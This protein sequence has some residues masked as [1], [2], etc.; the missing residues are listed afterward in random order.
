MMRVRFTVRRLMV[1]VALIAIVFPVAR[2]V[3]TMR[4]RSRDHQFEADLEDIRA[5][6]SRIR[7][8]T[9]FRS[10]SE[11]AKAAIAAD[12]HAKRSEKYKRAAARP[13]VDATID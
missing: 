11:K 2:W 5:K 3:Q 4:L 8:R 10:A 13:W 9:T 7:T 12:Y 6:V 1:V